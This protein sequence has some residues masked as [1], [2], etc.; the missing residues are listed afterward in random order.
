MR[1]VDQALAQLLRVVAAVLVRAV[2]DG[3]IEHLRHPLG[4]ADAVGQLPLDSDGL[5]VGGHLV[6][7]EWGVGA[8]HRDNGNLGGGAKIE[9]GQSQPG[10]ALAPAVEMDHILRGCGFEIANAKHAVLLVQ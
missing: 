5:K 6:E 10:A 3:V 4:V 8:A 1:A 2:E 7:D 9:E